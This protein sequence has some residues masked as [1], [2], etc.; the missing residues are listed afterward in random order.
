MTTIT[1]EKSLNAARSVIEAA[2]FCFLITTSASGRMSARLMQ[3]F[4]PEVDFTIWFGAHPDSRKVREIQQNADVLLAYSHAEAGAYLTLH[5]HAEV[6]EDVNLRKKYWRES[7]AAF[8]PEGPEAERYIVI[9]FQPRRMELMHIE[10]GVAP[11]PFG[12][13][14]VVLVKEGE[15]WS[16]SD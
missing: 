11:D 1:V 12:L 8:W 15:A 9:R 4:G 3:P 14:P 10:G 6:F 7:F 2:G 13:A 16:I 5:G